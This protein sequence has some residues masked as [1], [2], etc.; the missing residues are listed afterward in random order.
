MTA[1]AVAV[2]SDDIG[3]WNCFDDSWLPTG[4]EALSLRLFLVSYRKLQQVTGVGI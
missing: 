4:L 1:Y 2:L 3:G